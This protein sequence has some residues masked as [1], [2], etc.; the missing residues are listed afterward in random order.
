MPVT[1]SEKREPTTTSASHSET[2]KLAVFVPCIPSIPTYRSSVPGNAPLPINVSVTGASTFST[3]SLS[4]LSAP[5]I[6][7]PPPTNTIGFLALRS[8]LI[9]SSITASSIFSVLRSIFS[10][11]FGSYSALSLVAFFAISIKT[12]PGLPD[13]AIVKARRIVSAN[14]STSFTRKLYFVIGIATPAISIS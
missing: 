6:T 14:L 12:G 5:E 9:A 10:G 11:T 8:T 1:R 7:A 13:F 2:L 4:S 3:N